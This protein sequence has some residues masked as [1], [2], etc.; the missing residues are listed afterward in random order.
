MRRILLL[1]VFCWT[2][3]LFAQDLDTKIKAARDS[4]QRMDVQKQSLDSLNDQLKKDIDRQSHAIDSA[5]RA[6]DMEH[7]NS[8]S[9]EYF[10]TINRES[11][12]AQKRKMW[13]Y[14]ALGG[15]GLI[16]LIVGLMRKKK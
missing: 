10:S 14:F 11:E 5:L 4:F 13:M 3:N 12:T 8:N 15:F 6:K 16:V 7:M 9:A 2:A 1:S